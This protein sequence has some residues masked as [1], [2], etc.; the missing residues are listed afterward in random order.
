M[1]IEEIQKRIVDLQFHTFEK[2]G[3]TDKQATKMIAQCKRA[4]KHKYDL[5]D[6]MFCSWKIV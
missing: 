6:I 3:A 4:L 2:Q 1:D 5:L